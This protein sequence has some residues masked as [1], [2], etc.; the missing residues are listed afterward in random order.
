MKHY[1]KLRVNYL[2]CLILVGVS[3]SFS[4]SKKVENRLSDINSGYSFAV[5]PDFESQQSEEGFGLVNKEKTIVIAVKNHNFNTF[6]KFLAQSNLDEDGF[7]LVGKIQDYGERGKTFLVAKQTVQGV[8]LVDTFVLFSPFGGGTVI[9]A[10]SDKSNNQK[11]FQA[12]MQI[13]GSLLFA[14]PQTSPSESLWQKF[15][16]GKHL[17]YLYTSSGFSERTDIYLCASGEF[18]YRSDSSSLSSNGSGATGTNSDGKWQVTPNG[19]N[20]LLHFRSGNVKEYKISRRQTND[21]INLNNNRYF[22]RTQ[23]LCR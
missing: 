2:L 18:I 12:A 7:S 13:A 6:D 23:N 15:L 1:N 11:G 21:E 16:T 14:K 9:A 19:G 10:F 8:L 20:L 22:V 17:L 4:Q 5:P 3:T